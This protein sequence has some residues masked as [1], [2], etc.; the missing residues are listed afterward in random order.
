[1]FSEMLEKWPVS[2]IHHY[3]TNFPKS[4]PQHHFSFFPREHTHTLSKHDDAIIAAPP[5]IAPNRSPGPNLK[6]S[7]STRKFT[8]PAKSHNFR[9][10]IRSTGTIQA[11]FHSRSPTTFSPPEEDP[12]FPGTHTA[13][14]LPPRARAAIVSDACLCGQTPKKFSPTVR[15]RRRN[16]SWCGFGRYARAPLS[17]S[18]RRVLFRGCAMYTYNFRMS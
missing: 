15:R 17:L 9:S 6:P 16:N 5:T 7:I 1:M 2:A 11:I 18:L 12:D 10:I 4:F 8:T 14:N 13:H 3:L